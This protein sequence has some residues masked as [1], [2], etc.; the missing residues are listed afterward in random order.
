MHTTIINDCYDDNAKGRQIVKL[1]SL[2]MAS[3]SFVGVKDDLEAAGNL[4]DILDA[5]DESPGIVLVNVAPRGRDEDPDSNGSPFGYF[6]YGRTLVVASIEGRTLELVKKL[7]LVNKIFVLK[8]AE[9]LAAWESDGRITRSDHLG[10]AET[11]FR[12]LN[13]LPQAA[14]FLWQ[15]QF[16]PSEE[17]LLTSFD[18]DDGFVWWVDNFG[19]CKTTWLAE[20]LKLNP[21]DQIDIGLEK[22]TFYSRLK[23]V[24]RGQPALVEGSSGI[25][26]SRFLEVVIQGGRADE[27]YGLRSGSSLGVKRE[28]VGSKYDQ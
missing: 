6:Y 28:T 5:Y 9:I 8:M 12:S 15:G 3:V 14:R 13:F 23:D 20:D 27:R 10:L 16:L 21:G 25:K 22:L 4:V 24:P 19:N 18:A 26:N 1:S 17:Q 11:Q 2:I 7:E